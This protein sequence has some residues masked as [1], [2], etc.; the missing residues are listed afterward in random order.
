MS[1]LTKFTSWVAK[2][3]AVKPVVKKTAE[4]AA[5]KGIVVDQE[6]AVKQIM[7]S[8]PI[9]KY[10]KTSSGIIVAAAAA[11]GG[12]AAAP[13]LA[14]GAAGGA[15]AGGGAAAAGGGGAVATKLA[16]AAGALG[17]AGKALSGSA[18]TTEAPRPVEFQKPNTGNLV[19][20]VIMPGAKSIMKPTSTNTTMTL[21]QSLGQSLLQTGKNLVKQTGKELLNKG[22]EIVNQK[23]TQFVR[24]ALGVGGALASTGSK[25]SGSTG[26]AGALAAADTPNTYSGADGPLKAATGGTPP[27]A[28]PTPMWMWVVG[29]IAALFLLP[30]LL[31]A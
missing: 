26:A 15:A 29:I 22:K 3:V 4:K 27:P 1:F 31:K 11:A 24:G 30:K 19:D 16:G 7:N 6:K 12:F 18:K 21:G 25:G 17:S 20:Q 2:E 14:G 23:A 10:A 8:A 13:L 9:E 5:E 28:E